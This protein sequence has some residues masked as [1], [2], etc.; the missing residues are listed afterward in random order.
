MA[1]D[2]KSADNVIYSQVWKGNGCTKS[3]R[4]TCFLQV[5]YIAFV[6]PLCLKYLEKPE[7]KA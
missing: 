6:Y 4:G 2:D 1:E 5:F 3:L 7:Q